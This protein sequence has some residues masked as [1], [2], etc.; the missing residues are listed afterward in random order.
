MQK[1]QVWQGMF[2]C[3]LTVFRFLEPESHLQG[4]SRQHTACYMVASVVALYTGGSYPTFCCLPNH[5]LFL[6]VL[7]KQSNSTVRNA[8]VYKLRAPEAA[9]LNLYE[10]LSKR[11]VDSIPDR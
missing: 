5:V 1:L 7:S 4:T 8:L 6:Q 11:Y 9:V 10:P 2:H 3:C